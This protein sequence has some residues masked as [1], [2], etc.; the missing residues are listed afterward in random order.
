MTRAPMAK[1][2]GADVEGH[3]D[4]IAGVVGCA[5]DFSELPVLTQVAAA[6]LGVGLESS[7]SQHDRRGIDLVETLSS[8]NLDPSDAAIAGHEQPRCLRAIADFNP[9]FDCAFEKGANQSR[10]GSDRFDN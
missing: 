6:P 2:L 1:G 7:R 3:L 9:V 4:P 10:S 5:A 8:S